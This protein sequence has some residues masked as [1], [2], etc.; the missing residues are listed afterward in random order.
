MARVDHL[1]LESTAAVTVASLPATR[2]ARKSST[3]LRWPLASLGTAHG[4]I[5]HSRR[6]QVLA[7]HFA[8]LIPHGHSVLD[9]G[10]GD[11]LIDALLLERRPDLTIAGVDVLVRPNAHVPVTPFDGR[12]LPFRDGSWDTLLFCDVL[13]HTERPIAMLREAVRVARHCV[14]IKDH[15]VQGLF[16]RPTLRFMDF[17]GNAPHDVLLPYNYFTPRQWEDAFRASGLVSREVRRRLRLY[18]GWA[19]VVFGRSLHFVGAYD[20]SHDAQK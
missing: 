5:V 12:R 15:A 2:G 9:V 16:A 6:V 20:I 8:D 13:H 11:G 14:V 17:V 4:K 7:A 19:D 3:A 10:C 18:P 1:A